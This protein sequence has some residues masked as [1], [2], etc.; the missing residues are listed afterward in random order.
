MKNFEKNQNYLMKVVGMDG[1]LIKLSYEGCDSYRVKAYDFQL[2]N[3][4]SSG[5]IKVWVKDIN[6]MSGRPYLVQNTEWLLNETYV[7]NNLIGH[8]CH[9][10]VVRELVDKNTNARYLCLK[11]EFGFDFHRYYIA[12]N[13]E[14]GTKVRLRVKELNTSNGT[15]YLCLEKPTTNSK[16]ELVYS[17]IENRPTTPLVNTTTVEPKCH[18]KIFDGAAED[19]WTEFKSSI[20]FPAAKGIKSEPNIDKQMTNIIDAIAGFMNAD[21][22]TLYIGVRN[23]GD[24]CGIEGDYQYLN[25]G[26]KEIDEYSGSYHENFDGFQNKLLH[27]VDI[28]L[29]NLA[30]SLMHITGT[31]HNGKLVAKISIERAPKP[32]FINN[33][34]L[35]QRQWARTKTLK[36]DGIIGLCVAKS[37]G[38]FASL[39]PTPKPIQQAEKVIKT[40]AVDTSENEESGLRNY[41]VWHTLNLHANGGWSF[42]NKG[43]DLGEV[44]NSLDIKNY[45]K[46]EKQV[47]LM[48]YASGNVNVVEIGSSDTWNKRGWGINGLQPKQGLQS[49]C[50]ANKMD[51]VAV[52]YELSGRTFTKIVDI[53]RIGIH[54]NLNAEGNKL[55]PDGAKNVKFFHIHHKYHDTLRGL[56]RKSANTYHG[57]DIDNP[58]KTA[59]CIN[60]LENILWA[61]YG[62]EFR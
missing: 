27:M 13:E 38:E 22:G 39:M 54:Q 37:G 41:G 16:I 29:G 33:V 46:K 31:I 43:Q 10:D 17:H 42:D 1:N 7:A 26:S 21:G 5:E 3:G 51:M 52:F 60:E 25:S 58:G 9:F 34:K 18:N 11:D 30:A 24:V 56:T 44:T 48:M 49:I 45:H 12:D 61:E 47:L 6:P 40:K 23:N 28:Y 36:G 2:E 57:F 20:V 35:V 4:L 32:I 15:A 14:Y 53:K 62:A 55:V 50:C 19:Q 59:V 8:T